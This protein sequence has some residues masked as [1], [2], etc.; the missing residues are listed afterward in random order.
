MFTETTT[1]PPLKKF[2]FE[3][4]FEHAANTPLV[5][6]RK[7]VTLKPDQVDALKQ[8][9]YDAGF[10]D[11]RQA[12]TD[13]QNTALAA[14]I[15]RLDEKLTLHIATQQAWQTE[16]DGQI[17]RAVL[18]IARKLLPTFMEREGEKEIDALMKDAIT[19]MV[20][21]PRLVVRVHESQFESLNTK[22]QDI[23]TQKAYPGKIIVLADPAIPA[24]DCHIEWADGGMERNADATWKKIEETVSP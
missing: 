23:A 10:Q 6:E 11:G 16:Q 8:E 14:L 22:V 2:L 18:A 1:A 17:R 13:A 9:S 24:G 21:E 4:S 7:P 20:H 19:E 5:P 12:G 15:T 3:R